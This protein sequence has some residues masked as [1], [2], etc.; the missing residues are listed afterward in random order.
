MEKEIKILIVEDEGIQAMGL[1]ET[2]EQ[3][4]YQVVGIADSSEEVLQFVAAS[5]IDLIVMDIHIKGEMDGI[6]T[7]KLVREERPEMPIIYLTAY[8]DQ[9][10]IRRAAETSPA[11]Y[12]TKPYRQL[13]L[14]SNIEQALAENKK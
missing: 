6:D 10:T 4:G 8:M 9:E 1:E 3:A 13:Q 7:A 12:I 11:G 14:L 5:P 2:L